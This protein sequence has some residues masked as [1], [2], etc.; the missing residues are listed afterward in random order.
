ML[1]YFPKFILFIFTFMVSALA[2]QAF[3]EKTEVF[4]DILKKVDSLNCSE[5]EKIKDFYHTDLVILSDDKRGLLE[6]RVKGFQQMKS[7][8]RG[9]KCRTQRQVLA[10]NKGQK[11][12]YLLVDEISSITSKST[13]TDERQHSVCNY[14]FSKEGSAWK[15]VLEH[16]TSLPDYSIRPGDDALYY[17]HN[18]VY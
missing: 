17:F 8:F 14:V 16:C 1:K 13:D 11:M 12:G 15:I 7:E 2:S 5:P 10:G 18:P 3:A 9:L 4:S 6:N